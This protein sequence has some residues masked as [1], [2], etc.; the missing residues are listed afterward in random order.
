MVDDF[1]DGQQQDEYC[2]GCEVVEA[3]WW[4]EDEESKL[5]RVDE[6]MEMGCEEAIME[7]EDGE[8]EGVVWRL[9]P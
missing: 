4:E 7:E 2:V 1:F 6:V 8:V 9:D 5:E 3:R